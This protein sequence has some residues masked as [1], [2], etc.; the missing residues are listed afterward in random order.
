MTPKFTVNKNAP[1]Y[2]G[3]EYLS[4]GHWLVTRQAV[5]AFPVLKP[6]APYLD[7]LL[8][9]YDLNQWLTDKLPDFNNVIPKRDS[10]SGRISETPD[11]VTFDGDT[12]KTIILKVI[13]VKDGHEFRIGVDPSYLP[14]VR[15]GVAWT[16]DETSPIRVEDN[17]GN[18]LAVVMPRRIMK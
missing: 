1:L 14:I 8:G 7:K 5:R 10:M 16:K 9:K 11:G 15:L 17:N 4:N 6:L 12:I 2:V 3:E 18:L 13:S